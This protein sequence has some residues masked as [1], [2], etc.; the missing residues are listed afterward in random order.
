MP[1]AEAQKKQRTTLAQA[2]DQELKYANYEYLPEIKTVSFY[3]IKK[4]QSFPI[5]TLGSDEE[6]LL[7]FDDLRP[8]SRNLYYTVEHCDAN[9]NS[10]RL[11]SIE[12]L[13]SFPEERINDYRNSFNTLQ[14]Y[15]HY[16]LSL[17]NLSIRPK[18]S[19]NYLLKIYEDGDPRKLI[20]TRKFYV[21]SPML[22]IAAEMV[23]S[24]QMEFRDENQKI[25][26]VVN[27]GGLNIQNPYLDIITQVI[28]NGRDDLAQSTERPAFIR[29][30]QLVFNDFKSFDFKGLN[31]YRR[32]DLRTF[33]FK[34]E[35]IASIRSDSSINVTLLTEPSNAFKAYSYNFDENGRF[36]IRNQDGRANRTDADYAQVQFRLSG[37]K[38]SEAGDLYLVGAFNNY[39]IREENKMTYLESNRIFYGSALLK[40]G[41][42]DYQYVWVNQAGEKD[43][44]RFEGSYFETENDYQILVY[45][46]KTGARWD[47]LVGY[48]QINSVRP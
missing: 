19:G 37:S 28:Q 42:H 44:S 9:W 23:R 13:E 24:N 12:Y 31:E 25:N 27:T 41:I 46:R 45:Y 7:S 32:I 47:E 29:A 34:S 22:S 5:Y 33:R 39:Q 6:L 26:F 21:L 4:E 18:L 2:P 15:T 35:K 8:G 14:P 43:F 36:F 38:P 30:D 11:S 16:E 17:P 40:Q 10:S 1:W 3:N 20:L 48:L